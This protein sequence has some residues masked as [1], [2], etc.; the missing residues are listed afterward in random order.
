MDL[1]AVSQALATRGVEVTAA[2]PAHESITFRFQVEAAGDYR[3]EV[4]HVGEGLTLTAQGPGGAASVDPG[5]AGPF[6]EIDLPLKAA[7]YE[8]TAT[9]A[10][11]DPVFVDWELLLASGV[12]QSAATGAAVSSS[13]ASTTGI[14]VPLGPTAALPLPPASTSVNAPVSLAASWLPTVTS[15]SLA[16]TGL[17]GRAAMVG[18]I[19]PT[20]PDGTDEGSSPVTLGGVEL[21]NGPLDAPAEG[22][23]V[24]VAGNEGVANSPTPSLLA[25][26]LLDIAPD[27]LAAAGLPALL[28]E[29]TGMPAEEG[30]KP[31]LT[32][33]APFAGV[34]DGMGLQ[35][36]SP[37]LIVS[38]MFAVSSLRRWR[39]GW[40]LF[41]DRRRPDPAKDFPRS[42]LN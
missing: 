32:L 24:S 16:A 36:A 15:S 41:P 38:A 25:L 35:A 21:A 18:S 33:A 7:V 39:K 17:A 12:G 34:G 37:G 2:I 40:K 3:L 19:V 42:M 8:I 31:R 22:A 1:G 5:P 14:A 28:D 27:D 26:E 4:R 9:A 23:V 20:T 29:M 11:D 30:A 6:R 10:G 13:S